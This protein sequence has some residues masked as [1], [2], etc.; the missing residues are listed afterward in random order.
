M[1]I[2]ECVVSVIGFAKK[3][4][5]ATLSVVAILCL[6]S[7]VG[8]VF[9]LR[10]NTDSSEM[11]SGKLAFQ[12]RTQQLNA[13][14]PDIKN[15]IIAI[16]RTKTPDATAEIAGRLAER[17]AKDTTVIKSVFSPA[18]DPFF[19]TN[20]LLYQDEEELDRNLEAI[21]NAA[22]FLALLRED[23]TLD[24]LAS[25]LRESL[26]LSA[27]AEFD[28][29]FLERFFSTLADVITARLAAAPQTFSW[30]DAMTAEP[31]PSDLQTIVFITPHL[32]FSEISPVKQA[33]MAV[34]AAIAD[35]K[36]SV[37]YPVEID[38]TGDPILRG[39]ELRSVATGIEYS[40]I[41]SLLATSALLV[42]C[43]RSLARAALTLVGLIATLLLTTGFAAA[44]I[45]A[46]NLVSIA[47]CVLLVGL[48]LDFSIHVL[49]HIEERARSGGDPDQALTDTGR[50]V[51]SALLLSAVTTA[52]AFFAFIPT[53]F[54]GMSQLGLIGGVGVL[55]AFFVSITVIPALITLWP[56]SAN[57]RLWARQ[58]APAAAPVAIGSGRHRI[59]SRLHLAAATGILLLAVGAGFLAPQARFDA[60]PM[61]LR[62]PDSPSVRALAPLYANPDDAPYR[63]SILRAPEQAAALAE[64]LEQL[65]PVHKAMSLDNFVPE[66]QDA[67]LQV[68][69]IS[70]PSFIHI[71][72]GD[73]LEL[74]EQDAATPPV[75]G[76][77][78]ALDNE[79]GSPGATALA[80]AL[81]L[82][83]QS[84][85]E[86][87]V[88]TLEGD[89]FVHFQPLIDRF[90]LQ[91]NI[92]IVDP[93]SIPEALQTRFRDAEGQWRVEVLPR[94]DIRD[95]QA[96]Q[97]F[98]DAVLGVAPDAAGAPLQ[99]ARAGQV[100]SDA[101]IQATVTA[102][103]AVGLVCFLVLRSFAMVASVLIPLAV[104]AA[105]TLGASV[106]T[107]IP[108]NYANVIV[109][110]LLIGL[111]VDSGIHLAM[112]RQTLKESS[113]LFRTSTPRAVLFSALTTIAA[114]ASLG[115]SE[116][117]GTAS[118]GYLLT[119]A[120]GCTLISTIVLTPMLLDWF[121]GKAGSENEP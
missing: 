30:L 73:G 12:I 96:L 90:K 88:K 31:D 70:Y 108:F 1:I 22:S 77:I 61:G 13:A 6:A 20:G 56:G 112:R 55:V 9:G 8:S 91:L 75:S 85:S 11:L 66:N 32:D 62:S 97:G 117:R 46:L 106:L 34:E 59:A 68:I 63:L 29:T 92:D 35:V 72:E 94:D 7:V 16:V 49:A 95:P 15:S 93:D 118:M 18:S 4:P 98:V 3:R 48:G 109:L 65:G 10:I 5:R 42:L 23:R 102:I 44:A 105:L 114:F 87:L 27:K 2:E 17:L 53:D 37:S 28:R 64:T 40:L 36:A 54:T 67:K 45:G 83:L 99:I 80:Q 58:V 86:A 74:T 71:V 100:V 57:A 89:I 119:M 38:L 113:Q 76:L 115:L 121:V 25:A 111:G 101:M 51:G 78:A 110:P 84:E 24:A 82:V 52:F 69:E 120:I 47:F 107:G 103:A 33:R 81:R 14:F 39:D 116:H 79:T 104:A 50:T 21:N 43:Y 19:L 60:D 26:T 41:L